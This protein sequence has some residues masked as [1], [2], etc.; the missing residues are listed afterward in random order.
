MHANYTLFWC[1]CV[2]VCANSNTTVEWSIK[3]Q[4]GLSI[5]KLRSGTAL[6]I[7]H[8]FYFCEEVLST[9][10]RSHPTRPPVVK[11]KNNTPRCKLTANETPGCWY[12]GRHSRRCQLLVAAATHRHRDDGG[13]RRWGGKR[14]CCIVAYES[15]APWLLYTLTTGLQHSSHDYSA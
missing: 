2:C 6:K 13:I 4:P 12:V 5:T 15:K 9:N 3:Q 11:M 7:G 14:R 10:A 8:I 1:V